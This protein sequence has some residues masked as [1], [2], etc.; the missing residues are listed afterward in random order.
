MRL[1]V[2]NRLRTN[3]KSSTLRRSWIDHGRLGSGLRNNRAAGA[4]AASC[5]VFNSGVAYPREFSSWIATFRP[6]SCA[7]ET[8]EGRTSRIFDDPMTMITQTFGVT[9]EKA[10]PPVQQKSAP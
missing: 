3:D 8:C 10:L 5:G 1:T 2:A 6:L 4:D 7:P 9:A